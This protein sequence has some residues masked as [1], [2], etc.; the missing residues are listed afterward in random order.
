MSS[1]RVT[2][3]AYRMVRYVVHRWVRRM[4]GYVYLEWGVLCMQNGWV[5]VD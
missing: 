2:I 3:G 5:N 4:I 1:L